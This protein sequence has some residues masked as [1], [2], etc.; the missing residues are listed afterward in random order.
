[1]L[2]SSGSGSL[3]GL[4]DC[5]GEDDTTAPLRI[6]F[7]LHSDVTWMAVLLDFVTVT[8]WGSAKNRDFCNE[9]FLRFVNQSVC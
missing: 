4:L 3:L 2:L 9:Q 8:I 7:N 5:A 6:S 1:L